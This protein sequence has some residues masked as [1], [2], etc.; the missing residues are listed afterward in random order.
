MSSSETPFI[1]FLIDLCHDTEK[2]RRFWEEREGLLGEYDL[3]PEQRRVL[4]EGSLGAIQDAVREENAEAFVALWIVA[5]INRP[6]INPPPEDEPDPD[7]YS[8]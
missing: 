7:Q 5:P 3:S 6:P 8:A 4:Q 2:L 1:D